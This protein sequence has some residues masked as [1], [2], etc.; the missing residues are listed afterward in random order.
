MSFKIT[1]DRQT[2]LRT[3]GHDLL[4]RCVVLAKGSSSHR[5][6]GVPH[7]SGTKER[8][9]KLKAKR[10]NAF[11]PIVTIHSSYG[12]IHLATWEFYG[13]GR[14][15]QNRKTI[16]VKQVNQYQFVGFLQCRQNAING[17]VEL[18]ELYDNAKF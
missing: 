18:F 9:T 12:D 1:W 5:H 14:I 2:D 10:S 8:K 16:R 13:F 3:D 15:R 11:P 4:K 17:T 7:H 6:V